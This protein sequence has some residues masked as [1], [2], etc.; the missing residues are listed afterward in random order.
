ATRGNFLHAQ[1]HYRRALAASQE[2]GF[3]VRLATEG[4]RRW[5]GCVRIHGS[6]DFYSA[7]Y[8]RAWIAVVRACPGT[9]FYAYTRSWRVPEIA[10][11]LADLAKCQ[12]VRLWYSCDKDTGI[13]VTTPRR[14]TLAWMQTAADDL[15]S[16]A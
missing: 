3:A 15:P 12:N 6:G 7:E 4:K 10:G 5:A 9:R 16:R 11:A 14:V 8:V 13:P 2:D 1:P